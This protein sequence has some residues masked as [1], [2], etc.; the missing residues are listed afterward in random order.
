VPLHFLYP[1]GKQ[2]VRITGIRRALEHSG[3]S[4]RTCIFLIYLYLPDRCLTVELR[5][6]PSQMN[7]ET[8]ATGQL[9]TASFLVKR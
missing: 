9:H 3:R 6:S 8:V 7:A 5:E 4:L 2:P 1:S